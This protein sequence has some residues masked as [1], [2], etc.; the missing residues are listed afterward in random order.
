MPTS[1]LQMSFVLQ[2]PPGRENRILCYG[3]EAIAA[4]PAI[5]LSVALKMAQA[6][7]WRLR[8]TRRGLGVASI[9]EKSERGP[10]VGGRSLADET[11]LAVGPLR[12]AVLVSGGSRLEGEQFGQETDV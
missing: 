6:E 11:T 10:P 4:I 7:A 3:R 1:A 5:G 8:E 9:A 12:R 2:A